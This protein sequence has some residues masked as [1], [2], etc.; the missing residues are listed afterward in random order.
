MTWRLWIFSTLLLCGLAWSLWLYTHSLTPHIQKNTGQEQP[1]FYL[2]QLRS[3][4][5]NTKGNLIQQLE[6]DQ[7]I[8]YSTNDKTQFINPQI[9]LFKAQ[10]QPWTITAKFALSTNAFQQITFWDHVRI[11]QP[12]SANNPASTILTQRLTYK[13]PL[14]YAETDRPI[15]LRQPHMEIKSVGMR[16]YL[17]EGRVELLSH[18]SGRYV[19][20][21]S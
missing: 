7:A 21:S 18:A 13:P 16:A 8:H 17:D 6:A 12:Q 2:M 19:K 11:Q 15:T 1:D 4:R 3:K 14:R 20:Q 10:Q 5:F 9:I